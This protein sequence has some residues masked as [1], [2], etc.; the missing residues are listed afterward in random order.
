[1]SG[2]AA[3]R[4]HTDFCPECGSILPLPGQEDVV[5]CASCKYQIDISGTVLILIMH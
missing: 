1:M 5:T 3:F 4:S 2:K